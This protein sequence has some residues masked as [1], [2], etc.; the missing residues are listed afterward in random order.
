MGTLSPTAA[1]MRFL[2]AFASL[3]HF[4]IGINFPGLRI[5]NS[6]PL[7]SA[8]TAE[9]CT[10][11]LQSGATRVNPVTLQLGEGRQFMSPGYDGI[12]AYSPASKCLWTFAPAPGTALK[13]TCSKFSVTPMDPVG[14]R[15][16]GDFLRFY[17]LAVGN[18]L[19]DTGERYCHSTS[20]NFSYNS[21]IQVLFRSNLDP[22]VS[23]GFDCEVV[24]TPVTIPPPRVSS[25]AQEACTDVTVSGATST[26]PVVL[27]AGEGRQF[28]SPGFDG[29]S[30]YTDE[31][32]CLWTFAPAVGATL[33]FSCSAFSITSTAAV[34]ERCSGDFLRFYDLAVG[35][36]LDDTGERY[37]HSTPPSFSY[38][39]EIQ[40]LFRSNPDATVSTGFDCEVV[41]S[42]ATTTT[43]T[44]PGPQA[45]DCTTI[46]G[47]GVGK[48][49]MPFSYG[50][51]R[52]AYDGCINR[53][54]P[55][56]YVAVV[57]SFDDAPSDVDPN[58]EEGGEFDFV[59]A[60]NNVFSPEFGFADEEFDDKLDAISFGPAP[61]RSSPPRV[62]PRHGEVDLDEM[63]FRSLFWCA[64]EVDP[65]GYV[66]EWGK[67]NAGCKADPAGSFIPFSPRRA[68][69][70]QGLG[71]THARRGDTV[72]Q[73]AAFI[74]AINKR[75]QGPN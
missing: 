58:E 17:D 63:V 44:T 21:E 32:K 5:P 1:T 9:P 72:G 12:S 71:F 65:S 74:R 24:A 23:T 40:V 67:C 64:T 15:C 45:S 43:T 6:G 41:A 48:A 13:F 34:G 3:L 69:A 39:S 33:S 60:V 27:A 25:F 2:W 42:T 66:M 59:E 35:N 46:D 70:S 61:R 51:R 50:S 55:G 52:I 18:S 53:A 16:R 62:A 14:E 28:T 29:V 38:N 56:Q 11:V 26:T 30:G 75:N 47:P 7:K 37:C 57:P 20:P 68:S 54:P 8:F 36:S 49:C 22:V 73:L 10:D 31:S 19:D 4:A